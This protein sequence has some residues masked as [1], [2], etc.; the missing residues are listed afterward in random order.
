M[1]I[2]LKVHINISILRWGIFSLQVC[3]TLPDR[4][5]TVYL[6]LSIP[7]DPISSSTH[8][9]NAK[10]GKDSHVASFFNFLVELEYVFHDFPGTF[11]R[12][13]SFS[14]YRVERRGSQGRQRP[15]CHEDRTVLCPRRKLR[16]N[17]PETADKTGRIGEVRIRHQGPVFRKMVNYN[18]VLTLY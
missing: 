2:Y 17:Q 9:Q 15:V 16:R 11:Y 12:P 14:F 1:T 8:K 7:C 13:V 18:Q 5:R 3:D 6:W 4:Y 10:A